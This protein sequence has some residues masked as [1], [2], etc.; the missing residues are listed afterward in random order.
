MVVII[1]IVIIILHQTHRKT[2][3][4]PTWARVLWKGQLGRLVFRSTS[5]VRW[6]TRWSGLSQPGKWKWLSSSN[7]SQPGK[8]NWLSNWN[9]VKH[10]PRK[11]EGQVKRSS[12]VSFQMHFCFLFYA[13]TTY[14]RKKGSRKRFILKK[15]K[16]KKTN[17]NYFE[18]SRCKPKMLK[19]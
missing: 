8:W 9:L 14:N 10:K 2:L 1:T 16:K 13:C 4:S 7:L 3:T 11:I 17:K 12:Q 15:R 19:F 6:V 18:V 5:Q